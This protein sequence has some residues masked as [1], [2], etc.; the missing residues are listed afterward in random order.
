MNFAEL[1]NESPELAGKIEA[2]VIKAEEDLGAGA[3]P[4]KKKAVMDAVVL[5]AVDQ[6]NQLDIL[7]AL[8]D[9]LLKGD[10]EHQKQALSLALPMLYNLVTF[11]TGKPPGL[12][13]MLIQKTLPA[14]PGIIDEVAGRLF[15]EGAADA[16]V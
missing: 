1:A 9:A 8:I 3:G 13:E 7:G 4:E 11:F 15:G 12:V 2:A 16:T 5:S 10:E 6:P 14:L